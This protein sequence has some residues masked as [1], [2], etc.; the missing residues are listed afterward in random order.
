[1]VTPSYTCRWGENKLKNT[2]EPTELKTVLAN[3]L[4]LV[5]LPCMALSEF[6]SDV[7]PSN[8]FSA[9]ETIAV[10]SYFASDEDKR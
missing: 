2:A 10:F 9:E 8:L 6:A 3:L 1:M 7:V 5:R 4:P